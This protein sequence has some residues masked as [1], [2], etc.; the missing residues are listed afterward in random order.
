[1]AVV[2]LLYFD[3]CPNWQQ[4][5]ERLRQLQV[6]HGFTLERCKVDTP[7]EAARVGFAG[8]PTVLVD[9]ADPFA[10]GDEP[11]GLACRMFDTPDGP[12]GSPT[13][14]QL[15]TCWADARADLVLARLRAAGASAW[16]GRCSAA[17]GAAAGACSR[18][19]GTQNAAALLELVAFDLAKSE[20]LLECLQR[21]DVASIRGG[22]S[23]P[24]DRSHEH[25]DAGH[26][27]GDDQTGAGVS[28]SL[29]SSR[30]LRGTGP[31][32]PPGELR[33]WCARCTSATS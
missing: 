15:R 7:E 4:A 25:D 13:M 6:E 17:M 31:G 22:S 2:T 3:G 30:P 1:M 10:T 18:G 20:P 23:P 21:A 8:S 27:H 16:P 19:S 5:D 28:G 26:D 24:L 14:A 33:S 9:G 29:A 32:S 12:Q 11:T